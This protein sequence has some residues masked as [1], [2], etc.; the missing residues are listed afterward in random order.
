M[1]GGMDSSCMHVVWK[2]ICRFMIFAWPPWFWDQLWLENIS[3]RLSDGPSLAVMLSEPW[4]L[5]RQYWF[6]WKWADSVVLLSGNRFRKRWL[7]RLWK[8]TCGA[9]EAQHP[10]HHLPYWGSMESH[11]RSRVRLRT[12]RRAQKV[13]KSSDWG[14]LSSDI[15]DMEYWLSRIKVSNDLKE[16]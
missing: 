6:R 7:H 8:T 2:V 3:C 13:T 4:D 14:M 11:H 10:T 16:R 12:L 1:L 15:S 9:Q 5:S